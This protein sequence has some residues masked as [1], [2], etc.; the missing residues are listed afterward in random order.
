MAAA[1]TTDINM[2]ELMNEVIEVND[3]VT[4]EEFFTPPLADDGEHTVVLVLGNEGVKPD[5][6]WSGKGSGRKKTGDPYLQA[7][8]QLKGLNDTGGEAGTVAFDRINSI[9][10]QG[11]GTSRLHMVFAAAGHK[12]PARATLTELKEA[13]EAAIAQRPIVKVTTI[14][15]AQYNKGSKE[16]PEYV[17][18][19]KGQKRFPEKLGPDGTPTGK[20]EPEVVAPNGETVRAQVRVVKYSAKD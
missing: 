13:V 4:P 20:H 9:I 10:M 8:L 3:N 17:T 19:C 18:V 11:V 16:S 12:L 2:L 7:H 15:E 5:R 14:W 6:Q 1:T